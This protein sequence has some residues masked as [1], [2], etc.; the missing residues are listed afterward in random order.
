M[1]AKLVLL[2]LR[3]ISNA[4]EVVLLLHSLPPVRRGWICVTR[5]QMVLSIC[6]AGR[7][8]K[9]RNNKNQ[10]LMLNKNHSP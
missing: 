5:L 3:K 2:V 1:F 4:S 7:S 6:M 10:Q 8:G 9:E